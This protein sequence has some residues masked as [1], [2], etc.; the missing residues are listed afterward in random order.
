MSPR[1]EDNPITGRIDNQSSLDPRHGLQRSLRPDVKGNAKAL[2]GERRMWNMRLPSGGCVV[3]ILGNIPDGTER[4]GNPPS[5]P[6]TTV[7]SV[8]RPNVSGLTGLR[9]ADDRL[10]NRRLYFTPPAAF[11]SGRNEL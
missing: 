5:R 3:V 1:P 8:R 7:F 4:G 10:T 11:S 6:K 2:A 9:Q